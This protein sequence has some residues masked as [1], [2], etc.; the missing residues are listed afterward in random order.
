MGILTS[1]VGGEKSVFQLTRGQ[2]HPVFFGMSD[3]V[4]YRPWIETNSIFYLLVT[5][6][7]ASHFPDNK[8]KA[9]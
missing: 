6:R 1:V 8:Y 3:S 9:I 2:T 7:N 5:E 4:K